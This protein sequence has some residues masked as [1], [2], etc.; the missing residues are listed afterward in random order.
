MELKGDRCSRCGSSLYPFRRRVI[1]HILGEWEGM[2]AVNVFWD[3]TCRQ[4]GRVNRIWFLAD[5][6]GSPW[7]DQEPSFIAAAPTV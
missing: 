1:R 5:P 6:I 2:P 4:C 7:C 3:I